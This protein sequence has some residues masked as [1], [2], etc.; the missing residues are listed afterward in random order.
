MIHITLKKL[1][2]KLMLYL[3]I[4]S[5]TQN[6]ALENVYIF[7][8]KLFIQHVG[9]DFEHFDTQNYSLNLIWQTLTGT[10]CTQK[11]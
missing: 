3:N 11:F 4:I 6:F 5:M 2:Y 10:K 1:Y 8:G 9:L 7:Y